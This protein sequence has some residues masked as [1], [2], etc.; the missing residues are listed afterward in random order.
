MTPSGTL[1][2]I[3]PC[4]DLDASERFY[5]RLGFAR[6][7]SERPPMGEADTYRMLSNGNGG[8]LHLTDAVEGWLKPGQNPFG[9]YL[10]LEDVDA[11]PREFQQSAE[12]KPRRLVQSAHRSH[13]GLDRS[14]C[15]GGFRQSRVLP[16]QAAQHRA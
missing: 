11:A 7:D 5:A 2:A 10:Y 4:N 3:L 15:G 16:Q 6:P 12:D 9:L 1:V 8:Y 13:S 14:V